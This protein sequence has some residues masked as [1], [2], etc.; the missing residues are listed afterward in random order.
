MS[1]LSRTFTFREGWGRKSCFLFGG[2]GGAVWGGEGVR[3]SAAVWDTSGKAEEGK[4]ALC[5]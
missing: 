3:Y 5:S 4:A 1:G 2:G